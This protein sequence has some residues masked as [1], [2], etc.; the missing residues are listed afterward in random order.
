M[1]ALQRVHAFD[2]LVQRRL[3]DAQTSSTG[4]CDE[5]C[6]G[7]VSIAANATLRP[8]A[9]GHQDTGGTR[10]RPGQGSTTWRACNGTQAKAVNAM[11]QSGVDGAARSQW[12]KQAS[13][14]SAQAALHGGRRRCDQI[15]F[16][17]AT[18]APY[19]VCW[20]LEAR[21]CCVKAPQQSGETPPRGVE[22]PSYCWFSSLTETGRQCSPRALG[23][24]WDD[25]PKPI[26]DPASHPL[27]ADQC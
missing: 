4:G 22:E 26:G 14:P 9:R 10:L 19:R 8:G 27:G 25:H 18:L 17:A 13:L 1:L 3:P 5:Q 2:A 23:C 6:A 11:S 20:R 21:H 15:G 12:K 16:P 7:L 24:G